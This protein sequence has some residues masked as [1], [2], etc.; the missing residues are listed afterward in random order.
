MNSH[1]LDSS[2]ERQEN[3][4]NLLK[5]WAGAILTSIIIVACRKIDQNLLGERLI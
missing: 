2:T 4:P 1:L 5:L 3:L